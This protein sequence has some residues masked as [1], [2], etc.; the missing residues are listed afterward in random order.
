MTD[1][2]ECVRVRKATDRVSRD[3]LLYYFTE[4]R[5]ALG[6]VGQCSTQSQ[7]IEHTGPTLYSWAH[8]PLPNLA[9]G[10]TEARLGGLRHNVSEHLVQGC[11]AKVFVCHAEIR[12]R[13]VRA[14][15]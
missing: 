3:W 15:V 5:T 7:F 6:A 12:T 11:Y 4:S 9:D 2:T 8:G 1:R 10:R 14:G 13:V